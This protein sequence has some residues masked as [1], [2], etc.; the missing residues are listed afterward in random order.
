MLSSNLFALLMGKGIKHGMMGM[1]FAR[2]SKVFGI[3]DVIPRSMFFENN[4]SKTL[5]PDLMGGDILIVDLVLSQQLAYFCY[6]S[7]SSRRCTVD[8]GRVSNRLRGSLAE[9]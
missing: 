5:K 6:R 3:Y 9:F 2:F 8:S 1:N 4:K 7:L